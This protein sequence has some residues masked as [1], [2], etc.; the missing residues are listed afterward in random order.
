VPTKRSATPFCHGL[1]WLVRVGSTCI[2][3]S[4]A[5]TSAAKTA[6]RSK[7]MKGGAESNGKA[8][9]SC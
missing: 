5:V 2:D 4:V 9:R 7:I 1:R 6:S 8:S 3:R